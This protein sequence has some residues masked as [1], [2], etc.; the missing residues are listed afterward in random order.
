MKTSKRAIYFSKFSKCLYSV[1]ESSF[2]TYR[3]EFAIYISYD[4][5]YSSVFYVS[6]LSDIRSILT[7]IYN[8]LIN[9][10]V[11]RKSMVCLP[12]N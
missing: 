6:N 7:S 10:P 9:N 12:L 4:T 3:I 11:L 2:N 1:S 5:K 8:S